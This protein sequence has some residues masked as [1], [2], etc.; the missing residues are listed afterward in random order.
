[1]KSLLTLSFMLIVLFF[2]ERSSSA[3]RQALQVWG[4]DV[5][6]SLFP[7]MVLCQSLSVQLIHHPHILSFAAPVMGLFGGSPSGSAVLYEVYKEKTV[8]AKRLRCLC[9]LTGTI[10]PMFF[11]GPVSVWFGSSSIGRE[12]L[13]SHLGG[14][15]LTCAVICFIPMREN[16][17][18]QPQH[19]AVHS[20]R[21]LIQRSID[22]ALNVGGCII[23]FSVAASALRSVLPC[24]DAPAQAILHCLLE[25]SGGTKALS[26]CTLRQDQL[27]YIA[28]GV[29][30]F[31]GFSVLAQNYVYLGAFGIKM[32]HLVPLGLLRALFCMLFIGVTLAA[33]A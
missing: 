1:M 12:L 14:T 26:Q 6:P 28:A 20:N 8:S 13:L 16:S 7:Y 29:T 10:S 23:F 15:L 21:S 9:T 22:S 11:L 27:L 18:Q 33:G 30:G 31:G 5:V 4:L 25:I 17:L 24:L 19:P 32:V 3:A 2:P